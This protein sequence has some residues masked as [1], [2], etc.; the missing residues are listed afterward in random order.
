MIGMIFLINLGTW[1]FFIKESD[2]TWMLCDRLPAWWFTHSRLTTFPTSLI[3]RRW[4]GHQHFQLNWLRLDDLSLIGPAGIQ[5]LDFCSPSVSVLVLLL[6][7]H[8]V[9]SQ[10]WIWCIYEL[11]VLQAIRI[12]HMFMTLSRTHGE[13]CDHVKPVKAATPVSYLL[14]TITRRRFCYCHCSSTFCK[15]LTVC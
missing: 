14:L 9:S 10:Y 7:T 8:F 4:L 2:T 15:Y 13:D 6:S 5:L 1:L 3:A 11:E 12:T